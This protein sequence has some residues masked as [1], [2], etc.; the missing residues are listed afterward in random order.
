VQQAEDQNGDGDEKETA[1]L[2]TA[3]GLPASY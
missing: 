2:T 1:Y 3:F